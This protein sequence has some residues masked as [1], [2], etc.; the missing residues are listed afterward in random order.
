MPLM[1]LYYQIK[2]NKPPEPVSG[3]YN[4]NK[5]DNMDKD[6]DREMASWV[7]GNKSR[8]LAEVVKKKGI[9]PF[10]I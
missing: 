9:I 3:F 4:K 5:V 2:A 6:K 1:R 10:W 7:F 8:T